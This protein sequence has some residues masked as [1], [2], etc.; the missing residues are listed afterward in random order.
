MRKTHNFAQMQID[1]ILHVGDTVVDATIKA[2]DG[3]RYLASRVGDGGHVLAFS[4]QKK[5]IDDMAASLFLSGLT[6]RVEPIEKSFTNIPEYLS[7][8]E[9]ISV[10]LFQV[11]Q[12]TDPNQLKQTIQ[13]IQLY[14]RTLGVIVLDGHHQNPAMQEVLSMAKK[15]PANAYEVRYFYDALTDEAALILQRN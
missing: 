11:D 2:G 7:P 15:L 13:Q 8:T 1:E 6:A 12:L 3:T 4:D 10:F 14:L 9:L 5:E